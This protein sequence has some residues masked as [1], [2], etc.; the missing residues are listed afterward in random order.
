[1]RTHF[2]RIAYE[3]LEVCNAVSM[4]TVEAAVALA[5]PPSGGRAVD[6]GCGHGGVAIR[7]AERFG[8]SV[9]AIEADPAM[10]DLAAARI[11]ASPAA[12][13]ITLCRGLSGPVLEAEAPWDLI[14]ALGTTEPVGGG[15]RDPEG[16]LRGLAARLAPGGRILWGDMTWIAPP[17]EPLR[18]VV[19]MTNTYADDA[20]WR[21]AAGAAGLDVL[22]AEVSPPQAWA[23]Y[24][25]RMLGAVDA[26][27]AADPDHPD[28]ASIAERARQVEVMFRFGEGFMGFGLY[29]LGACP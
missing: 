15:V 24:R 19:E 28:A 27:L 22:W 4:A 12:E 16:M 3:A 5:A 2:H 10:A 14:V 21:A 18:Q 23:D 8:L 25:D 1:M 9:T 13:R 17:P 29:L 11:A 26:W 6:I 20:G 7:L